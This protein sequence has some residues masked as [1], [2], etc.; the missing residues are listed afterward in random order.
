M[1]SAKYW[2][3]TLTICTSAG[4]LGVLIAQAWDR[5]VIR[6]GWRGWSFENMPL[7]GEDD[8]I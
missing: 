6:R 1:E 3:I 2:V 8:D 7:E 4:Y 5:F